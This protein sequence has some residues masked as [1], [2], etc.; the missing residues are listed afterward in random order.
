MRTMK[1]NKN[2]IRKILLGILLT[3]GHI[4][5]WIVHLLVIRAIII[6]ID[7]IGSD[8]YWNEFV[9]QVGLIS[10]ISALFSLII[11][12]VLPIVSPIYVSFHVYIRRN[13]RFNIW[14]LLLALE[15][16]IYLLGIVTLIS[17]GLNLGSMLIFLAFGF[18]IGVNL[19]E[20]YLGK[21]HSDWSWLK[22]SATVLA[23]I[24]ALYSTLITVPFVLAILNVAGFGGFI[25]TFFFILVTSIIIAPLAFFTYDIIKIFWSAY[26]NYS[27]K[28]KQISSKRIYLSMVITAIV[29][30][31]LGVIIGYINQNYNPVLSQF[32]S[33]EYRQ[34]IR[35]SDYEKKRDIKE[36]IAD[37]YNQEEFR[38]VIVKESDDD[39]YSS[40]LQITGEEIFEVIS[41][42][43]GRDL[44]NLDNAKVAGIKCR[45]M[46]ILLENYEIEYRHLLS[47]LFTSDKPESKYIYQNMFVTSVYDSEEFQQEED[48]PRSINST[49]IE[50]KDSIDSLHHISNGYYSGEVGIKVQNRD[51]ND[52]SYYAKLKFPSDTIITGLYVGEDERTAQLVPQNVAEIVYNEEIRKIAPVDPVVLNNLYDDVYLLKVYPVMAGD[53]HQIK[54]TYLTKPEVSID[55]DLIRVEILDTNIGFNDPQFL[56]D[57]V[58]ITEFSSIKGYTDLS[59]SEDNNV[60][61]ALDL[62]YSFRENSKEILLV[63]EKLLYELDRVG[64]NYEIYGFDNSSFKIEDGVQ[65][66]TQSDFVGHTNRKTALSNL[67]KSRGIKDRDFHLIVVTDDSSDVEF[68]DNDY[69][70][71]LEDTINGIGISKGTNILSL[72]TLLVDENAEIN[73]IGAQYLN[74]SKIHNGKILYIDNEDILIEDSIVDSLISNIYSGNDSHYEGRPEQY[75]IYDDALELS[76]TFNYAHDNSKRNAIGDEILELGIEYEILLPFTSYIYVETE[77]QQAL[78]DAEM[79]SDSK[80]NQNADVNLIGTGINLSFYMMTGSLLLM[81]SSIVIIRKMKF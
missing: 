38:D 4:L 14:K 12:L 31:G 35:T 46:V 27:T 51:N 19:S 24:S 26:K 17:M 59:R 23:F 10:S 71:N 32:D 65:S 15:V 60:V 66:L 40:S 37:E 48:T 6:E 30:F 75:D 20:K 43:F 81:G 11:I 67:F 7:G 9:S 76:K 70:L 77:E 5:F 3:L 58:K 33:K 2:Q 8:F 63:Y 73:S 44:C 64:M 13:W 34:L 36:T 68:S 16:P 62:S 28:E 78:I 49:S 57:G 74:L 79:K 69:S 47:F 55:T 39:N 50:F 21:Y 61:V 25:Q 72:T 56:G 42:E 54:I 45:L 53:T 18:Y 41:D 80:Y 29:Y 1:V 52:S 22:A